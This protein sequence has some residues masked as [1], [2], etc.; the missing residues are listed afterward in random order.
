MI[1]TCSGY[2]ITRRVSKVLTL[3]AYRFRADDD[4]DDEDDDIIADGEERGA[5]VQHGG[6]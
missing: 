6:S 1:F 3:F 5:S 4:E 2:R